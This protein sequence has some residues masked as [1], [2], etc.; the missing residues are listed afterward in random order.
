M[1]RPGELSMAHRGVLFL[2]ELPEFQKHVLEVLRQP[3]EEGVVRLARAN[4]NVSYPCQ[5]MLVAAMNPCPCGYFNVHGRICMCNPNRV[6]EYHSR[7]SGPLLDRVD[8]TLETRSVDVQHMTAEVG[9]EK[10][11][12]WYRDRVVEARLR[13][14]AR[15]KGMKGVLCNAQMSARQVRQWCVMVAAAQHALQGAVVQH[16]LSARAHDRILKMARTRADLQGHERIESDDMHFAI[17]CRVVDRRNWL[18]HQ[19]GSQPQVPPFKDRVQQSV[20]S[21]AGEGNS[22]AK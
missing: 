3:L 18:K 10:T 7:V 22:G 8:I 4:Q 1:A 9:G 2:D 20:L 21:G 14:T 11:S 12:N 15:F 5:V 13:Q 17:G 6:S 16:S 19:M